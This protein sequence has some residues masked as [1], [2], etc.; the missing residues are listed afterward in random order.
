MACSNWP[1]PTGRLDGSSLDR[2]PRSDSRPGLAERYAALGVGLHGSISSD[3]GKC[4]LFDFTVATRIV[5]RPTCKSESRPIV[6]SSGANSI[7]RCNAFALTSFAK[8]RDAAVVVARRTCAASTARSHTLLAQSSRQPST[9]SQNVLRRAAHCGF[10]MK[11]R[12]REWHA[13]IATGDF[14]GPCALYGAHKKLQF[15]M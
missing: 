2:R 4:S 8:A 15:A 5:G 10:L 1:S 6:T 9:I 3:Q 12:K 11:S 13:N 7:T 14:V